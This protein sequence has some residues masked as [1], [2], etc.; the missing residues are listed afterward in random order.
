MNPSRLTIHSSRRRFAARLNS[1]VMSRLSQITSAAVFLAVSAVANSTSI[2]FPPV[3]PE[4]AAQNCIEGE[5]L[6]SYEVDE[7][8]TPVN[9]EIVGAEP[10]EIFDEAA[11]KVI[12]RWFHEEPPGTKKQHLIE[13]R[14]DDDGNTD[15]DCN[16]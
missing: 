3:Y 16:S 1:G 4:Y 9:I 10:E 8:G 2:R 15:R 11:I 13:F 6:V 14:L 5:V 7:N 12:S